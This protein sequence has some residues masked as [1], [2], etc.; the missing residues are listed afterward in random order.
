MW[1]TSALLLMPCLQPAAGNY[2]TVSHAA[3]E[4][5]ADGRLTFASDIYSFACCMC[6]CCHLF[7]HNSMPPI[8]ARE[9]ALALPLPHAPVFPDCTRFGL[10]ETRAGPRPQSRPMPLTKLA[11]HPP[12]LCHRWEMLAGKRM[13]ADTPTLQVRP[14]PASCP[15]ALK[16]G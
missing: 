15:E 6:G 10:T 13:W 5:M 1:L 7:G 4:R 3:P 9:Q 11:S 12:L 8:E 14:Q 2:G 16:P